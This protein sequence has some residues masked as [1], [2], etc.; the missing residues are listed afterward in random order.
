MVNKEAKF[1]FENIFV[2][3][4][5]SLVVILSLVFATTVHLQDADGIVNEDLTNYYNISINGTEGDAANITQ[6][7]I[8]LPNSNF[9][10]LTGSNK[11]SSF[12][13]N[14]TSTSL[15]LSW[16]NTTG[17]VM[18]GSGNRTFEFNATATWPG[19]YNFTLVFVNFSGNNWFNISVYINDTTAPNSS[20]VSPISGGNY[21]GNLTLN[22][23]VLDFAVNTVFFNVTNSSGNQNATYTA[24]QQGIY[25]NATLNTNNY[26]EGI[27]N[28][29]IWANDSTNNLN[30]TVVVANLRIDRTVPVVFVA[31]ISSPV[32]GG[33][34][35]HTL[36]LNVS[37]ID[38][39]SSI[40]SVVFNITNFTGKQNAT[41]TATRN[42][43]NLF[44]YT[45]NTAHFPDGI[46]NVTAWVYDTAGNL[47]KS[48]LIQQVYF[49]NTA[50][51]VTITKSATSTKTTLVIDVAIVENGINMSSSC[52]LEGYSSIT[53]SGIGNSQTITLSNKDCGLSENY[54]VT[55]HDALDNYGSSASTSLSTDACGSTGS[56]SSGGGSGSTTTWTNTFSEDSKELSAQGSVTKT[57]GSKNRIKLKIGGATH[58]V[59][60]TSVT[61]N[62]ATIEIS[63]TPQTATLNIGE[64][65][66]FDLTTD[67]YYDLI[68]K[69]N[70]I[71]NNKADVTISAISEKVTV[72]E[73]T[74]PPQEEEKTG[75]V[76][77]APATKG[78]LIGWIIALV[79]IITLVIVGIV[80]GK[81]KKYF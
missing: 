8:T 17:M 51:V 69:L 12:A 31:N 1:K 22:A 73:T 41:Y 76:T 16:R 45:I 30:K 72:E 40:G 63:S 75:T 35:S 53:T 2:G 70:S 10:F 79:V 81:K 34:Y 38:L 13:N 20:F 74:T 64:T 37:A 26:N 77:T 15:V 28:I 11:T 62:S 29:T 55:C 80:V 36:S 59:G 66:K 23:S 57:L 47:N 50:P 3:I 44:N 61:S 43:G 25:W 14:F 33:N 32:V 52:G 19:Y 7:N 18:N 9:T 24:A 21:S 46:Y 42:S 60:V 54:I 5:L 49:E 4:V 68:V 6:V 58:Y 67:G 71:T 27:Y 78:S 39:N 65:Q 56:G 48:A